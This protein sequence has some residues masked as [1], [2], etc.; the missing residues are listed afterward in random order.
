MQ[1]EAD[2]NFTAD[3]LVEVP[4]LLTELGHA[5][6]KRDGDRGRGLARLLVNLAVQV[7][8]QTHAGD[9]EPAPIPVAP[10]SL[11]ADD[12]EVLEDALRR[13]GGME[14]YRLEHEPDDE[15]WK[16]LIEFISR[17]IAAELEMRRGGQS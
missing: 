11:A 9:Q 7:A 17:R 16:F 15:V 3:D 6:Y 1:I 2:L 10:G 13:F 14:T 12:A 4:V 8:A 5:T